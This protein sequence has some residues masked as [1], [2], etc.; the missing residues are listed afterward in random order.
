MII[1]LATPYSHHDEKV[2]KMRF[3][4]ANKVAAWIMEQGHTCFSP[5][6]HSHSIAEHLDVYLLM[7]HGFWMNQ[8][9][10]ILK[11]CDELW[12]YPG[13]AHQVSRGVAAE[14]E[15][16]KDHDI[17]VKHVWPWDVFDGGHRPPQ[18]F[19]WCNDPR[20]RA[21]NECDE[22]LFDGA[23]SIQSEWNHKELKDGKVD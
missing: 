15:Y 7:D 23:C 3:H 6:S 22:C 14:M 19:G 12:I 10:P 18:C 9:L 5:I 16:A 1:Y 2:R 21:E 4:I 11:G 20:S 13:D 8:D 17:K